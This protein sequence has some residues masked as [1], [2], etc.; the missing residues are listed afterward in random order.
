MDI[1]L[2]DIL[3]DVMAEKPVSVSPVVVAVPPILCARPCCKKLRL[4]ICTACR[5]EGYCD[6]DCQ[7]KDW[8]IHKILCIFMKN[9]KKLLPFTEVDAVVSKLQEHAELKK[10]TVGEIRILQYC[11]SFQENQYD[12]ILYRFECEK[13]TIRVGDLSD[14][15]IS[16]SNHY[17]NNIVSICLSLGNAHET[18]TNNMAMDDILK[19]TINKSIYYYKKSL[20]ILEK[21]QEEHGA[22]KK[23]RTNA[24]IGE[25]EQEISELLSGIERQ[26]GE[27]Q[28]RMRNFDKAEDYYDRSL[29]HAKRMMIGPKRIELV[30]NALMAKGENLYFQSKSSEAKAVYEECYNVV[31]EA[32]FPDHP[33]VLRTA[34]KLADVLSQAGEPEN[35]EIFARICYEQ[36]SLTQPAIDTESEEL[37]NA[38]G[39]VASVI[40]QLIHKNGQDG[41]DIV[42]AEILARTA[43]RI[44]ERIYS[45]NHHETASSL[46]TLADILRVKGK[47][48]GEVQ[49]LYERSLAIYVKDE[50]VD[51]HNT[52]ILNYHLARFHSNILNK[53]LPGNERTEHFYIAERYCT[54]AIRINTDTLG[55]F[56]PQTLAMQSLL[57]TM[58][59][60]SNN[61]ESLMRIFTGR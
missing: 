6:I 27:C 10:G 31:A 46:S 9:D 48:D 39:S 30:Q 36:L 40:A 26:L 11:L 52:G 8:K 5:N 55:P 35:A 2:D 51:S 3:D 50:G 20:S 37:G 47:H 44:K 34:N 58:R 25:E 57:S 13:G 22:G 49:A 38:A 43:L 19:D 1:D 54:E 61:V 41:G 24:N 21:F 32:Y 29:S 14:D 28:K 59:M 12:R 15:V 33:M 7:R 53:L 17:I 4:H 56:H 60:R 45:L 42:E 23:L 16:Q 18:L